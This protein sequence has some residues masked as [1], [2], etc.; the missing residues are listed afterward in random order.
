MPGAHLLPIID[1]K[2][3]TIY[4]MELTI[5]ELVDILK[6]EI[7]R[8]ANVHSPGGDPLHKWHDA[9]PVMGKFGAKSPH[10]SDACIKDM[11]TAYLEFA[12]ASGIWGFAIQPGSFVDDKYVFLEAELNVSF[13]IEH[14]LSEFGDMS[15]NRISI[16]WE[17]DQE[18]NVNIGITHR[19]DASDLRIFH[20]VFTAYWNPA[21][22]ASN[23]LFASANS[24]R[25]VR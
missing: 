22:E 19:L 21:I 12:A 9:I 15:N 3:M 7:L 1:Y 8:I 24:P 14:Q 11:N 17:T 20:R 2:V 25:H 23:A 5:L 6:D 18:T 4:E 16:R 13:W 10:F